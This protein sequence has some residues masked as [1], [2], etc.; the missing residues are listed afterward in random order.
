MMERKPRYDVE[1]A[2]IAEL[3]DGNVAQG[4]HKKVCTTEELCFL[5]GFAAPHYVDDWMLACKMLKRKDTAVFT[6]RGQK[7]QKRLYVTKR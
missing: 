2:V 6:L 3:P 5:L 4:G 1:Y 7:T